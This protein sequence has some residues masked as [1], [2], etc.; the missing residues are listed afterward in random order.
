MSTENGKKLFIGADHAGYPL[1][2]MLLEQL[3]KS[4]P[5]IVLEDCGAYRPEPSD[6]PLFAQAVA[7]KV[8]SEG[9]LG[10]LVCGSGIGMSITAN[11]VRGIRAAVVWDVSSARMAR[12]HNN[13][14]VLCLG[15]RMTANWLAF[16][17]VKTWITAS[18]LGER[19]Q[20]RVDLIGKME[21][22]L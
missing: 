8:A 7:R 14:N 21:G 22:C 6:Y 5:G 13:A 19:H 12:E 16:E 20:G 11:K 15:A 2:Q 4:F 17:C 18:F 9:G 3:G 10:I 1:K